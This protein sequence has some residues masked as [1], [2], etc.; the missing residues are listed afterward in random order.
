MHRYRIASYLVN[1]VLNILFSNE[2]CVKLHRRYEAHIEAAGERQLV[3]AA[4]AVS[5]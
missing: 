5:R 3:S 4:P 2:V 1:L